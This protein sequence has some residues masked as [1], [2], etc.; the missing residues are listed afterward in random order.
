MGE[1]TFLR[2]LGWLGVVA[3]GAAIAIVTAPAL[4]GLEQAYPIAQIVAVRGAVL[5]TTTAAAIVFGVIFYLRLRSRRRMPRKYAGSNS[6]RTVQARKT[7]NSRR[8]APGRAPSSSRTNASNGGIPRRR[9]PAMT[10]TL[11]LLLVVATGYNGYVISERGFDSQR[12]VTIEELAQLPEAADEITL[13][14]L[15]TYKTSVPAGDIAALIDAADADA[16][17]LPE[18]HLGRAH[19]VAE[20]LGDGWTVTPDRKLDSRDTSLLVSSEMGAYVSAGTPLLG[21]A[22]AEPAEDG[23]TFIAMHPYPPP[24]PRVFTGSDRDFVNAAQSR[25]KA[26]TRDAF[27]LCELGDIVAGD[28]NATADHGTMGCGFVDAAQEVGIGGMGTWPATLPPLMA[29]PIDRVFVDPAQWEPTE[30]WIVDMPPS[31]HRAVVI[32]VVPVDAES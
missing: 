27:A 16:V 30:G 15:N 28:F 19:E 17:F 7:R 21:S 10:L 4:V 8:A 9:F 23:P 14:S 29:A 32:R 11:T 18:T 24:T 6:A 26:E 3:I 20:L 2:V 22:V 12:H 31:D 25:W 13:V 5:M 1:M